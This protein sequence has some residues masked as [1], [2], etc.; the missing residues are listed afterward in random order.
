MDTLPTECFNGICLHLELSDL[1][2]L[3]GCSKTLASFCGSENN[4]LWNLLLC[5]RLW[6]VDPSATVMFKD[7]DL[8]CDAL[9]EVNWQAQYRKMIQ[10]EKEHQTYLNNLKLLDLDGWI[11]RHFLGELASH[12]NGWQRR[13]WSWSS[14][15]NSFS[16][17]ADDT[18]RHCFAT[19]PVSA[20]STVRRVSQEE[21]V[22]LSNHKGDNRNPVIIPRLFVFTITDTPFPILWACS[23]QQQLELWV[24]KIHVTLHPLQFEGKT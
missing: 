20:T 23:S 24:D 2:N 15:N 18:R 11:E 22:T 19:F 1:S 10:A 3:A 14:Q 6:T 17:W 13:F 5:Q 7:D 4:A 21:Q 9:E 12:W 16:I 8:D